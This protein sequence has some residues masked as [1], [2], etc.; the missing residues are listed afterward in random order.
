MIIC[1]A[2]AGLLTSTE[3]SIRWKELQQEASSR[4]RLAFPW[5][6]SRSIVTRHQPHRMAVSCEPVSAT[7]FAC[8]IV[9]LVR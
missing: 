7:S 9:Q 1:V 5:L 2:R 8:S 4:H 3:G 6:D